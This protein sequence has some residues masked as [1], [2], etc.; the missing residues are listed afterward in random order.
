LK[1]T[2]VYFPISQ[3][4]VLWGE[5]DGEEGTQEVGN[6]AVAHMNTIVLH[7]ANRHVYAPTLSFPLIGAHGEM[8]DGRNLF[9]QIERL[10]GAPNKSLE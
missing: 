8:T 2:I 4:C 3:I 6:E 9:R 1:G 5:F 7:R 10:A